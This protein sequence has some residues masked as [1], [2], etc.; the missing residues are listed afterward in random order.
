MKKV[1]LMSFAVLALVATG[2]G[3]DKKEKTKEENQPIVNTNENV[4]KDQEVNGLSFVN[5]SLVYENG[6]STL[7]TEVTNN[8]GADYN[9]GDFYIIVKD[10]N[11]SEM[12]RLLAYVGDVIPA[13]ET[14]TVSAGTD[15]D[16]SKAASIEYTEIV[17]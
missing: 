5:T 1:A 11:G 10:E 2:C 12:I 16:L 6:S 15:M 17:K 4:V 14:R 13:G 9:L 8:T 3:C 7:I